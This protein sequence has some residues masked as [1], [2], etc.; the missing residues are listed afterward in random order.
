MALHGGEA[1]QVAKKFFLL[2]PKQM[3]QVESFLKSLV[4][5]TQAL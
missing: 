2:A 4:A 1:A 3:R 5:P